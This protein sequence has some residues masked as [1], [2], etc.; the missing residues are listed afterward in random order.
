ME[1]AFNPADP[2]A[3]MGLAGDAVDMIPFVTGVG[4]TIRTLK[5]VSKVNEGADDAID[6][7]RQLK[8]INKGN[9]LEA[10]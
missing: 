1:V 5:T 8:K 4:E 9:D 2:F 7:Y 10:L 3:W 6:T